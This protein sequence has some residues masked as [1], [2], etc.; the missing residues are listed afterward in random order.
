MQTTS[1]RDVR[2]DF[3]RGLALIVIYITH[4]PGNAWAKFTPGALGPSDAAEWFVFCSGVA[5]ALAFGKLFAERGWW[6][7][8]ARVAARIWQLYWAQIALF[9]VV[10]ALSVWATR[11]LGAENYVEKLNL[12]P[13]FTAPGSGLLGLLSLGYVPNLFDILPMYM[14]ILAMLPAIIALAFVHPALAL[15]ASLALYLAAR[16]LGL[17][18]PAEWWSDRPWFFNPLAWQLLFVVGFAFGRGWLRRPQPTWPRV[19][20]AG[21]IVAVLFALNFGPIW[22]N[23]G[24]VKAISDA[25]LWSIGKTDLGP[26]RILHFLAATYLVLALLDRFPRL[27][28]VRAVEPI[29][30]IG[31]QTLPV[32]LVGIVLSWTGGMALDVLGRD[33]WTLLLVNLTGIALMIAVARIVAFYVRQARP[34]RNRGAFTAPAPAIPRKVA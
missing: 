11:H 21:L 5:S 13:F 26:A 6:I 12:V 30:Q 23:V 9:L 24:W 7:G 32:F 14:A 22:Q 17:N 19:L 4:I 34:K 10:A 2:L 25:H 31:Q 1:P 3:F 28:H 16:N 8:T 15:G 20:A 29:V 27:L 18:L 33:G